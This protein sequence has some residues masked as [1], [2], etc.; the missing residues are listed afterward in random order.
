MC[1]N[2]TL[3]GMASIFLSDWKTFFKGLILILNVVWLKNNMI[4]EV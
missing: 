1:D 3:S 4:P 2:L